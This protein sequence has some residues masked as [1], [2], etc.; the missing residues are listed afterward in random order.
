MAYGELNGHVTDD[1]LQ[2]SL[3]GQAMYFA[4]VIIDCWGSSSV[5]NWKKVRVLRAESKSDTR[6]RWRPTKALRHCTVRTRLT[7]DRTAR[8][9]SS[10][11]K[12]IKTLQTTK[13]VQR[14]T[15]TYLKAASFPCNIVEQFT[16]W[17]GVCS[18]TKYVQRKTGQILGTSQLF[19]GSE[20]VRI[21]V[22]SQQ[23]TLA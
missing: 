12:Q 23:V 16:K 2:L 15:G 10:S 11:L 1:W 3:A 13:R 17:C 22:N 18:S 5:A 9:Q 20:F 4:W 7:G 6:T 8:A 21:Q 19:S 14:K